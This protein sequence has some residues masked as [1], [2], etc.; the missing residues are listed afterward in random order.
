MQVVKSIEWL[1][2]FRLANG[3]IRGHRDKVSDV[4]DP[5]NQ[6]PPIPDARHDLRVL[7]SIR[8]IIRAADLFSRRL[9]S[10]QGVTVPQLLC[11]TQVVETEAVSIKVL[12]EKVYLS[13]STV[14][15]IVDRLEQRGLVNR[16]RSQ[17]D[18]RRV[19]VLPTTEGIRLLTKSP[20][21]LQ[22]QF[23][24]EFQN[25]EAADQARIADVLDELVAL[26][27][28]EQVAAAPILE[29]KPDL[30]EPLS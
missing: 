1:P 17:V 27:E 15:G 20:V 2:I 16:R 10:S 5:S 30:D 18:K 23:V 4:H 6:V 11:L 3:G 26:M 7:S 9:I 22:K 25:L 21:P 28:I 19:E 8:R 29:T 24:S 12:A 14:V 13:P